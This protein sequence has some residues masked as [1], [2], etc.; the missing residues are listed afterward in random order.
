MSGRVLMANG[1][2]LR[3]FYLLGFCEVQEQNG[4]SRR[5]SETRESIGL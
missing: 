2:I 1:M 4:E 5:Q 3:V